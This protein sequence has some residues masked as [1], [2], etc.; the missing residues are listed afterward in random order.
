MVVLNDPRP[1]GHDG[2]DLVE[3]FRHGRD[4]SP[5]F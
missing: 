2:A 4:F 5:L 1:A 3:G